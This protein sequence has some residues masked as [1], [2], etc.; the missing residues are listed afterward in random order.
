MEPS[1]SLQQ[2]SRTRLRTR[3]RLCCLACL[4]LHP[5][6]SE[7][8]RD[9]AAVE[10][11]IG[12][13]GSAP[14]RFVSPRSIAVHPSG[15]EVCVVDRSGRIQRFAAPEGAASSGAPAADERIR[16]GGEAAGT[17]WRLLNV[18]MLPIFEIGQPTGINYD[19]AGHLMVADTHYQRILVYAPE[20]GELLRSFGR[21]GAGPGEFTQV[22]DVVEDSSGALFAADFCGPEDRIQKF[23]AGGSFLRAFGRRGSGP[24]EFRR[25]QGLAVH[26]AMP[27]PDGAPREA[28][29]VAD[30]CNH[31]VQRFSLDGEFLDAWGSCGEGLG[32]FKYPFA[33]AIHRGDVLVVEWG[34]NRI[35]RFDA[36]G[37]PLG[38]WGGPGRGLGE[39][40]TP[41][42]VAAGPDGR[43]FVV[44]FGNHRVQVLREPRWRA[45]ELAGRAEPAGAGSLL[46]GEAPLAAGAEASRR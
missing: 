4:A 5:G 45:G 35:Q 46:S 16:S 43:I 28:L 2:R 7:L 38:S 10:S 18:W 17:G 12:E 14:A 8:R 9:G 11:A 19:R 15:R 13:S 32:E 21:A 34:N 22:R 27:G 44:D 42:D 37:R 26:A 6:C 25:P 40:A 36:R 30:S 3:L 39:L 29:L 1:P 20:T 41:W 23:D 33:I 31:R 24:G